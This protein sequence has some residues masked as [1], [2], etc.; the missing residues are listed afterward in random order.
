ME[1]DSK[2]GLNGAMS[3]IGSWS[4]G[5]RERIKVQEPEVGK[6]FLGDTAFRVV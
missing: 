6:R 2:V 3:R 1:G 4:T 5:V